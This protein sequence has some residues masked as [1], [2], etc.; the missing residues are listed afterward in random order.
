MC[1]PPST[2]Q[3]EDLVA[4]NFPPVYYG[5]AYGSGVFLQPDLYQSGTGASSTGPMLDFIF[6][7]DDPTSWHAQNIQHNSAHYSLM[8][9]FG[10]EMIC[11]V[12]N[13]IGVGV[14]FNTLVPVEGKV[15]RSQAVC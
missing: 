10:S 6:V 8:K 14:Y 13:N 12:A 3:L 11:K 7:V 9:Y 4:R 1:T 5:F 15:Q 2:L